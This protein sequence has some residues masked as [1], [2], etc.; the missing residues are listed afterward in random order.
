MPMLKVTVGVFQTYLTNNQLASYPDSAVGWIFSVYAFLA[1]GCGIQIGPIFDKRG[2]RLLIFSGSVLSVLSIFL[3]GVCTQYW[4]F[5][6]AFGVIGGFGSSLL[7]TPA[8]SAIGHFFMVKRG[9]ATGFAAAGGSF[10]GIIFPLMLDSLIPQVGWAWATRILAFIL[11]FLCIIANLFIRSRLPPKD[12]GTVYPDPRIFRDYALLFTTIGVWFMEW[13]LFI[14]ITYL[15]SYCLSSGAMDAKFSYQIM[16]I[17]NAGSCLGR[18][19]PGIIADK[20]GRFNSQILA[21]ALCSVTTMALWLPASLL[22]GSSPAVKPIM[23]VFSV[24]FGF[25]SGSNIS[26]TPV[27]VG[28][29]C[30]TQEYGRYYATCYSAVSFATLT[31]IPIAGAILERCGGSYYGVVLFTGGSYIIGTVS[32]MAARVVKIDSW[33]KLVKY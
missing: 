32:F 22:P 19:L 16:A 11:L 5:M 17:F 14:P 10:G 31:G 27:C 12:G 20:I 4:H 7:F 25:A 2:P 18:W 26:L 3:L 33:F 6:L 8:I 30:I 29:L 23:I 9:T 15:I 13:G 21:F 24:L 28:Q 1:F